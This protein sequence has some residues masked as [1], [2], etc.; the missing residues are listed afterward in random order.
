MISRRQKSLIAIDSG[1]IN[2]SN[3][4]TEGLFIGGCLPKRPNVARYK[5]K[6]PDTRIFSPV[7][8]PR[9]CDTIGRYLHL[10]NRLTPVWQPSFYRFEHIVSYSSGK[11][12]A[13]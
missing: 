13:K 2:L 10:F 1:T 3:Q 11:V 4:N 9:L 12:V 6:L 8:V 5:I 7:A